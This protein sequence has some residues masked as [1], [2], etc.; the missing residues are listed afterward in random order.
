MNDA[1]GQQALSIEDQVG[2]VADEFTERLNRG[3]QPEVEEYA[4]R[5][6]Q[7]A[8]LLR[9]VLPALQVMGP[10]A[11]DSVFGND[12]MAPR[13][14]VTGCLGDYR[15]LRE[16]GRG[17]MGIVYE[18]EQISLGRRVA[19]KVLP[20]AST[21]DARQLQRFKNEAHA[22]GQ[23]HH[24]NIVPVYGTGCER[25][26]HYYAMQFIDGQTVAALIE[27]LRGDIEREARSAKRGA[28]SAEG[29]DLSFRETIHQ[30]AARS[31]LRVPR[32]APFFRAVARL[33]VQ[34][35][36]ALE[37]AH[38]LGVVHRD[39]KPANLLVDERG[40]LWV[41]DFGLA[42]CH[43]H[44][45]L[46]MS[47]DLLGTLRYMSPE[48]ALAKRGMVDHRTDLYSLGATLYELLTLEP[49]FTGSDR[50]EL[51][52]QIAFEEPLPPRRLLKAIPAELETIVLKAME[53]G[54]AERYASAQDLA[55]DLRHFLDDRPI[56]A[57]R[58]TVWHKLRKWARRNRAVVWSAG[59]SAVA[60]LLLAVV[61]LTLG[62]V[63]IQTEQ[64]RTKQ[65]LAAEA[66]RRQQ[67]RWSLDAMSSQIIEGWLAR[68]KVL[69]PEHKKFL[70]FALAMYEEL[71]RETGQDETTRQALAGAYY[72][73]GFIRKRL[74]QVSEAEA[75][76][77][78]SRDL[79]AQLA[80]D[81]PARPEYQEGL[82][83]SHNL[84]GVLWKTTGRVQEAEA[85]YRAAAGL[86]TQL[87]AAF[88]AVAHYRSLLAG[89]HYNLA[90]LLAD[91]GRT[92]QAETEYRAALVLGK[93]LATGSGAVPEYL[94]ALAATHA[95]LGT[96]L[97]NTGR[98]ADAEAEYRAALAVH[99]RLAADF[100]A[101][102]SRSGLANIRKSL[103]GLLASTGRIQEAEVELRGAL[104][105]H[106][107]L[108]AEFPSIAVYRRGQ[109]ESASHLGSLLK[110]TRRAQEAE[111]ELRSALA[112]QKR[113]AAGPSALPDDRCRL[114]FTH[115]KL[116]VLLKETGRRRGAEIE[117]RKTLA[118]Y[119]LL[120]A[121]FPRVSLYLDSLG[122]T[123]NN[124]GHLLREAG[125]YK[126][127]EK[128]YR[129]A[130][131]LYQPLA[132]EF[133]KNAEYRDGMAISHYGLAMV[134]KG[135]ERPPEAEA[136]YRAA[137][138]L[139][140]QLAKEDPANSGYQS[141]AG[142]C[143]NDL[144]MLLM[145]QG[146]QLN[147]ARG[148]LEQAVVYQRR[149]LRTNSRQPTYRQFLR[150][151]LVNLARALVALGEH[152]EAA[153][154]A[155]EF[156]GV[157]PERP[158]DAHQA[159]G[160]LRD[161]GRLAKKD[162]RL[163]P[164]QRQAAAQAYAGL[165]RKLLRDAR[166]QASD[167]PR[168]QNE[169]AWWLATDPDLTVRDAAAA[170]ELAQRA[171]RAAPGE[172]SNWNTLGVARYR[173]GDWRAASEAFNRS[174]E[175]RQGGNSVDWFF[176]AMTHWRL[177]NKAAANNW[178]ERGVQWM[179]KHQPRNEELRRFRAEAAELL[180]ILNTLT[181][182]KP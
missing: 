122:Q 47:G 129:A 45:G 181:R 180:D 29:G 133:P 40:N 120:V 24:T 164:G 132:A 33:G 89:S 55:E 23:L 121:Q 107:Q 31:T 32:S 13:S 85:A 118:V 171:V 69:L 17:G 11:G 75:A 10:P 58:P 160:L 6:P 99:K 114:A 106:K 128:E 63:G 22:A 182:K 4:E 84:L 83:N 116:G 151:H 73:V 131:A 54:P 179:E 140:K 148:L 142:A 30:N 105:L 124:L 91:G 46:T 96:L 86:Q 81:F 62:F 50:Q 137:V 12:P 113:L 15:L 141:W 93:Q 79:Y 78:R 80:D 158:S 39:I 5:Y 119:E 38:G 111:V 41:T 27:E 110:D 8:G 166:R 156:A 145:R 115:T 1:L 163:A 136:E 42:H 177:G 108:A 125:Q 9:Q 3:E 157:F 103:G 161:C 48:Q 168:A 87:A 102:D 169:L 100:P 68:Q 94:D 130:L 175:L 123:R 146:R 43:S 152:A 126:K 90:N 16:V 101:T 109:A 172:G 37:H 61:G 174:M 104:A 70:E 14:P 173:A 57:R 65:A 52:R 59:I 147:E 77:R 97:K 134:L 7:I 88:P 98:G 20:F 95:D 92:R 26:V 53:K 82:A 35:A 64:Q 60:V 76:L 153:R 149:A 74:G 56:R 71:A 21:L 49:A 159:Y 51:L 28:Q 67:L 18:A 72:R 66:R 165:A 36:E 178:Y 135:T 167:N 150:N 143:L 155:G 34:A 44:V 117:F 154:A 127:A 162:L 112:L 176:L 138:T 139:R 19:L 2:Q 25:G 144:A 170:V